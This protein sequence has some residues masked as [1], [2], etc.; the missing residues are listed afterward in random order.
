MKFILKRFWWFVGAV[1]VSCGPAAAQRTSLAMLD[2]LE[3]GN[4]ELR[5]REAGGGV[6]SI[7]LDNGRKLIQLRHPLDQCSSVIVED[8]RT[9]VTVQYTCPGR[10]YGLTHIRWESKRLAQIDS[11]GIVRGAPF[12]FS[13]EARRVGDCGG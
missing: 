9:E 5:I 7:C 4:W 10:G 12:D 1:A 6:E 13:A 2:H 3:H 11:R 8:T